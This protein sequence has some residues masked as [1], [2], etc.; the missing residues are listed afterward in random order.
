[1]QRR[2][3]SRYGAGNAAVGQTSRQARQCAAMIALRRIRRQIERGENRAE[4]Q[5]RAELP[6]YQI[7]VLTLPAETGRGGKRLFHHC[8]GIDKDFDVAAAILDQPAPEL[9]QPRLDQL[10]IIVAAGI[11]RNIAARAV[12]QDRQRILVRPVI[13]AEHDDRARLM[14]HRARIAA[15]LGIGRHPGHVAVRAGGEEFAQPLR[16]A[17]N[18]IGRTSRRRRQ[19]L[20]RAP[21]R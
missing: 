11:D 18:R 9:F 21:R 2:A 4:E 8:C 17:R 7:G 13:D 15:P 3:S 6:R 19:S 20:A 12:F 5:P 16:R 10:V 1:M 14:P